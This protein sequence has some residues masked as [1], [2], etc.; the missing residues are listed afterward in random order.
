MSE[1]QCTT[2]LRKIFNRDVQN[3]DK[4]YFNGK[5]IYPTPKENRQLTMENLF[6][7]L[8]RK[9]IDKGTQHREFEMNL[10]TSNRVME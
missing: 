1:S 2:S 7:H 9:V 6:N 3:N 4:F 5:A 8:T 10:A